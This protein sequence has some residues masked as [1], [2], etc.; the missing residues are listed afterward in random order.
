ML[1]GLSYRQRVIGAWAP[2]D[3]AV[4][5]LTLNNFLDLNIY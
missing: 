3:F 5:V 2:V 1:I 4:S